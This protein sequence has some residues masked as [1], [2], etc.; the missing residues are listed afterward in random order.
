[1][2]KPVRLCRLA[3]I[4]DGGAK[5]I[6]LDAGGDALD[7]IVLRRGCNVFAYVNRCPHKGTPLET[8]PDHFLDPSGE[9]LICSTH[10]ARFRV[11][12]GACVA[13][14]CEG[15]GLTAVGVFVSEGDVL[16]SCLPATQG[17]EQSMNDPH[18]AACDQRVA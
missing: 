2:E 1:M 18:R 3:D 17:R 15:A 10:G 9:L 6:E 12:D 7:L 8:F 4:S 14:P 5:G 13:G 16:L 11:H